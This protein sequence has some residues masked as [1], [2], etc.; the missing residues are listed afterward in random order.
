MSE[1]KGPP[2]IFVINK[3]KSDAYNKTDVP[4]F[5]IAPKQDP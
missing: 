2:P 1:F 4:E 3:T 5:D